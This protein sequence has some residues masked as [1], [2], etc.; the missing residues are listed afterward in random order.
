MAEI[1]KHGNLRTT[2]ITRNPVLPILCGEKYPCPSSELP[3]QGA[4]PNLKFAQ[5]REPRTKKSMGDCSEDAR[6]TYSLK[7]FLN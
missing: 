4:T 1:D 2:T 7:N 5:I 3:E 6:T